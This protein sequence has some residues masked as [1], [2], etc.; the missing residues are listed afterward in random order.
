MSEMDKPM[1]TLI[2]FK[3]LEKRNFT[4]TF[5]SYQSI[6]DEVN[7]FQDGNDLGQ[8]YSLLKKYLRLNLGYIYY[9]C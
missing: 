3:P 4:D 2:D 6:L 5:K 9:I 7:I 8:F 1:C